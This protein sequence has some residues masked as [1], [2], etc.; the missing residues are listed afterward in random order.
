MGAFNKTACAW[1][2]GPVKRYVLFGTMAALAGSLLAT[3]S[4]PKND[5]T[6]AI[7][8]LAEK[9]NYGWT[10]TVEGTD[11]SGGRFR[12][13]LT[14]GKTEKH[15]FTVLFT[16]A[17]TNTFE[18]VLKGGQGVIKTPDGWKT[19]AEASAGDGGQRNPYR[20]VTRIFQNFKVPAA[21]AE[22]LV[23]KAK[24]LKKSDDA[25][26]GNLTEEAV[27]ELLALGA[28][29]GGEVL[30]ELLA[31][32]ARVVGRAASARGNAKGSVKF[33]IKDGLLVKYEVKVQGTINPNGKDVYFDRTRTVEVKD[34]GTTKV[35][36]PD[37][38]KNKLF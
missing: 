20:S 29:P 19:L 8:M 18:V 32:G 16:T 33:W 13:G 37:E 15:G 1:T 14:E 5:I 30:N 12:H 27:K 24:R 2:K 6:S 11:G 23:A 36:V 21:Q 7:K 35:E 25:Y 3:C 28:R 26:T 34:I 38:A 22:D 9:D 17:R 31:L 10:A 4:G